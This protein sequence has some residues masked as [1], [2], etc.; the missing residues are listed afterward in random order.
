MCPPSL[1][2]AESVAVA[3]D[4]LKLNLLHA[5]KWSPLCKS[6]VIELRVTTHVVFRNEKVAFMNRDDDE[7]QKEVAP[8][9]FSSQNFT[10]FR[11]CCCCFSIHF[12]VS[13][14]P[15]TSPFLTRLVIFFVVFL[16]PFPAVSR[17]G[18][19]S[20]IVTTFSLSLYWT[21]WSLPPQS[22][23]WDTAK[24]PTDETATTPSKC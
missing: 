20:A 7:H 15:S 24:E 23:D 21:Y 18:Y 8:E 5:K 13:Q 1:V 3:A 9:V 2:W 4:L 11:K 22:E 14:S 12:C 6:I 19:Q 17:L 10:L 16:S